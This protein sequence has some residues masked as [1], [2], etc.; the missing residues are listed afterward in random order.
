MLKN[1]K[2]KILLKK[3]NNNKKVKEKNLSRKLENLLC[4]TIK[5]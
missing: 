5:F 3:K 4:I 2:T 1:V